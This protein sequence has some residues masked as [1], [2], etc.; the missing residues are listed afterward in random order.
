MNFP[1]LSIITFLPLLGALIL[2]LIRGDRQQ[3]IKFTALSVALITFLISL[4]V[5]FLFEPH[6]GMQFEEIQSWIPALGIKYRLGI[7]GIS[8]FMVL[9]TTFLTPLVI[10]SSWK[11]I[12]KNLKGYMI[13]MLFL[14]TG[15]L[16][17]FVA[18]DL[19]LFYV[20]WEAMLI[21]MYF[22]IGIWGGEN[23]IY[24]AI[25]FFIYTMVGS[26]LMLVAILIL[27]F[28]HGGLTGNYTF[29]ILA[30][31]QIDIPLGYQT[32]LFLAFGLSFAIKVPI[33]PF[34][35]WLPDAHVEAPTGGSVILAGVLLKMGTY[36]FLRF[37]LPF[38]PH[39]VIQFTPWI[40][41]LGV[42]GIIYGA[43]VA[44]VQPD[45]KKLVAYSSV[46]HLGFVMLGIFALNTQG[47][48]GGLIQMVN[49]GL[50][51]GAL[52]LIVGMIYDRRHTRLIADFGGL[53]K[54]IPV[55]TAFFMIVTLSSIGLPGLNGFVGEF[56]ILLGTF[57]TNKVYAILGAIGVILA[58][59]YMLR[60][61]QRVMFGKLDKE[62][63]QKLVDLSVREIAVL[64][65]IVL[66]IV[67]IGV[68]PKPFLKKME[69][70]VNK[71][72]ETV[73]V[74]QARYMDV[75]ETLV[76]K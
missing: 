71:L 58:A 44:M 57:L 33:F 34:H 6:A 38:F 37:C 54:R 41:A 72:I 75:E 19:F 25:K 68:Y 31:Q 61:F 22:I 8:L 64:V 62:E 28:Y 59:V 32:W 14:E 15:M 51:T 76:D 5:Y 66:F 39:A 7:D 60:M 46:S 69:P 21:P 1:F 49:H 20:F 12:S 9:L 30:I 45:I 16:G 27:Y 43:L 40:F 10:L 26:L 29:D 55:F 65:P 67:F 63:N 36:G 4:P 48:Q 24:A 35:T 13:S 53:A 50:S 52:F 73:E 56:L 3:T 23:R 42:I 70:T 47:I 17:V 18:M 2:F 74:K 11:S